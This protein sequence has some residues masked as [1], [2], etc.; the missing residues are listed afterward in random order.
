MTDLP[1]RHQRARGPEGVRHGRL[2]RRRAGIAVLKI[3]AGALVVA[4]VSIGSVAAYAVWDVT[5]SI[6]TG[7]HLQALPG[8]TP[9]PQDIPNVGALPGGVN[10]L[11]AGTDSRSDLGGIYNSADEQDASSGAGN[12]DVTMLLHIAQD[13]KSMMVVSFPRDLMVR[14]PDCPGPNGGTIDGSSYAQF[15]TALSRGGLNCVVA[16]VSK[17]TGLSIPFAAVIN[18]NGVSAMSDAV[19]G[20][21]VCL[22][23]PV[24]DKYTN[25]PLDLPAGQNTIVGDVALSFLRSRHGVGDG[26]DLGRI[27]N[28]QVFLSALARKVVDGGVLSNPVQLYA[29]AKA[30]VSNITPSDTLTN[31]TTLVQIA[32]ALKDTGLQNMVFVQY[33]AVTD[34]DNPNRV[35]PQ[36]SAANALNQA[37]VNDQPVKLTGST[38]RAAED[39]TA[40]ASPPPTTGGQPSPATP[41]TPAAPATPGATD[42]A[43]GAAVELP[44]TITGQT[45]AQQTCTKGND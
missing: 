29:L 45:A 28:Q 23:S 26:S 1:R 19:G 10:L 32:L 3:L 44:S 13:H 18:F 42:P 2:P 39:P 8:Q 20:V 5:R 38:G 25:P 35:V 16:T 41:G 33:P 30:A 22:A 7:V 6:K 43:A 17:M 24:T 27:S 4:V 37:L 36:V 15:N 9:I 11:L 40:T 21:T 31:P 12:N 14:I 34:P